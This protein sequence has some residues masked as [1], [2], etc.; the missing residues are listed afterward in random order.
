MIIMKSDVVE[1][2]IENAQ[3]QGHLVNGH[4][5]MLLS[6][7]GPGFTSKVLA[8]Y[9][10]A[11]GIKHIFGRPYHPQ[12][13]GKIERFHKSI[14]GKV[15]LLMVY[16]SP[17]TLKEAIEEAITTYSSTPHTA[18]SNVSA[19]DVYAGISFYPRI[20]EFISRLELHGG[21]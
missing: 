6:D 2:A 20:F 11:H 19:R 15:C 3:A 4:R 10:S 8:G 9:L 5:P 13:H 21:D 1:K 7:N 14:K 16:C 17:E 12:T 18:L